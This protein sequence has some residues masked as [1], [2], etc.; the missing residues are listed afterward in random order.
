MNARFFVVADYFKHSATAHLY[1]KNKDDAM[2][3]TIPEDAK[4]EMERLVRDLNRH[5]YLY[6]VLDAPVITDEEYDRLYRRLLE[7]EERW[8]YVLPESPTQRV[9]A[10]PA[11]RFRKIAHAQPML[12]LENAFSYDELREFDKRVKRLLKTDGRDR[13]H[14]GAQV[15]RPRH[16]ADLQGRPARRRVHEGRRVR[17]RRHQAQRHDHQVHPLAGFRRMASVPEEIDIRGEVYMNLEDFRKLNREREEKGEPAFANPRNAAAGTREAAR[18]LHYR[19]PQ[20]LS[21]LLRRRRVQGDRLREPGSPYRLASAARASPLPRYL[22]WPGASTRLSTRCSRIERPPGFPPLRDRRGRGKGERLLFAAGARRE[23]QGAALG[24]RL[25]VPG[26]PGDHQ[27]SRHQ[28]QRREDGRHHPLCGL[29]AGKG[30]RRHRHEIDPAQLGRDRAEGHTD[31]RHGRHRE[32]RGRDPPRRGRGH[33]EEDR[34]R[35]T[36]SPS[37]RHARPAARAWRGRKA[38]WPSGASPS[39]APPRCRRRSSI[40]PPGAAWTSRASARR[41]WPS[42]IETGL[43][44]RFEDIYRLEKE[45]LLAP[46]AIRGKVG[47]EPDRRH[48]AVEADDPRQVPLSPSASPTWGSMARACSRSTSR[49]WRTSTG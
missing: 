18:S 34:G 11:E 13:L 35:K 5:S 22:L 9:G 49:A 3:Q 14:G 33:G 31:R 40:L 10:P 38:R 47:A 17:G 26:P 36:C 46:A 24:D 8:N 32:G 7:L 6:Y 29:R 2:A 15:R 44:K 21:G 1:I 25:Q 48:R 12:S 19:L 4:I 23:D 41:T 45:D 37:R 42:S 39:P 43:I 27:D 16:R 20:A 30:R 28:G